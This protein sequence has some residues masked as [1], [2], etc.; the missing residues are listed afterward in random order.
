MFLVVIV[1]INPPLWESV[2]VFWFMFMDYRFIWFAYVGRP[3]FLTPQVQCM[4]G[5]ETPAFGMQYKS[6]CMLSFPAF[7]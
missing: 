7:I 4:S 1:H 5:L 2:K 3:V 6:Y